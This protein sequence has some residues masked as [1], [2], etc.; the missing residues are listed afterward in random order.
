MWVMMRCF[1]AS[2]VLLEGLSAIV[3]VVLSLQL[4]K[5]WSVPEKLG[6]ILNWSPISNFDAFLLVR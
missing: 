6:Y 1:V 2:S 3:V 4:F 5:G